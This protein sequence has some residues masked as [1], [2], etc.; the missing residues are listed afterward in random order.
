[1]KAIR[2]TLKELSTEA[3]LN[4]EQELFVLVLLSDAAYVASD[5]CTCH[6]YYVFVTW[7]L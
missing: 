7:L 5:L 6:Y 3:R 2:R 1:M 4:E